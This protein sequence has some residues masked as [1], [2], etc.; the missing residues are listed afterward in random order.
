MGCVHCG[1]GACRAMYRPHIGDKVLLARHL[2]MAAIGSDRNRDCLLMT[3][4][5]SSATPP[6]THPTLHPLLAEALRNRGYET[7]TAVQLAVADPKLAERDLLV[8]SKTGS[9][10]TVAYGLGLASVL[11]ADTVPAT[12]PAASLAGGAQVPKA[13]PPLALIV[14][15]TRELA[16]QVQLELQWLYAG[17]GAVIA[18]C[19]GGMD[20][21][22]ERR[23]LERGTHIVVGTPGR[24]V[25]HLTRGALDL[26]RLAAVVLDEADEMLN[27]GFREDL[28][29]ILERMPETRRALLFSA[30]L[31]KAIVTLASRFQRNAAR[32]EVAGDSRGH[33]DIDYRLVLVRPNEI[34]HGVVNLLRQADSPAALVFCNTRDAVRHLHAIL[35]ERG[36]S[37]VILSGELGQ[38]ERNQA[39]QALRDGRAKV[40]IATDVAARGIDL[41]NLDLVIHADIPHDAEV[42]QHRSGRTGRAGRKG[43]SV[44]L[45]PPARR[46]KAERLLSEANIRWNWMPVPT[47]DEIRLLDRDRLLNDPSLSEGIE[48][49]DRELGAALLAARP[50]EDLAAAL[51]RIFRMKLPSPEEIEPLALEETRPR[52]DRERSPLPGQPAAHGR[53]F[54]LDVGRRDKAEPKNLLRLL[55]RRGGIERGLIGAIRIGDKTT[56][57]EIA[58]EAADVFAR[59]TATNHPNDVRIT[60]I[61]GPGAREHR[62]NS[63]RPRAEKPYAGGKPHADKP[64]QEKPYRDKPR[65]DGE[66]REAAR[67][68]GPYK[69]RPPQDRPKSAKPYAAKPYADKP[70]GKPDG[71]PSP[72]KPHRGK[73]FPPR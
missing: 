4:P 50:A 46:R 57:V 39:L 41:P 19:V 69:D 51:A 65:Q 33:T 8:S 20:A 14:A 15:P 42:L 72:A 58:A 66:R 54:S 34:E 6:A 13:G 70:R 5:P 11:L 56:E 17:A 27:L 64:F 38:H 28:E 29:F 59:K 55:Q 60:P 63:E 62:G 37:A 44:V 45:T 25:D 16:L 21:R 1:I 32:I 53:W 2:R 12:G 31:P 47:A 36:F 67:K 68:D 10:K 71:K 9:G 40:C 22:S 26:S 43:V 23:L 48:D 24:L 73:P 61:D 7:L 3:T 35:I 49:A 18:S 52:R 30:T